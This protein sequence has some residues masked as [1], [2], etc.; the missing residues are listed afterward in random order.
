MQVAYRVKECNSEQE[1]PDLCF[2]NAIKQ[3]MDKK[4]CEVKTKESDKF[5]TFVP[6]ILILSKFYLFTN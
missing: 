1:A 3:E 2:M 5:F 4:S 6:C